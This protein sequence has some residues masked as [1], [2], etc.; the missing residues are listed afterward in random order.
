MSGAKPDKSIELKLKNGDTRFRFLVGWTN[1]RG[2]NYKFSSEVAEIH[3]KDGTVV[4]PEEVYVN[5]KDWSSPYRG[6][7]GGQRA[8]SNADAAPPDD[9]GIPF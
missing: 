4:Q 7:N 6:G 8:K 1:E 9:D 5:F 3:F 2:L